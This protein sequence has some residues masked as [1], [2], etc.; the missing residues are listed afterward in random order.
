[1]KMIPGSC[2]S[3]TRKCFLISFFLMFFSASDL[4]WLCVTRL[5]EAPAG[6]NWADFSFI[7]KSMPR[8]AMLC[9]L[10]RLEEQAGYNRAVQY[11]CRI[12]LR[13]AAGEEE[14]F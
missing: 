2:G 10:D 8:S 7:L 1:M 9:Q 13:F 4:I 11:W 14:V 5:E 12:K 6:S 3:T